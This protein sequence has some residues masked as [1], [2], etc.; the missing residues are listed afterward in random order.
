MVA[1]LLN[2]LSSSDYWALHTSGVSVDP[3]AKNG[4][5][6]ATS[7]GQFHDRDPEIDH[8]QEVHDKDEGLMKT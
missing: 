5:F 8:D 7:L 2:S 1:R 4:S 6:V 3:G